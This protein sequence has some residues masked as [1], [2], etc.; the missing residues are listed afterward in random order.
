MPQSGQ[1]LARLWNRGSRMSGGVLYFYRTYTAT[2]SGS[3]RRRERCAGCSR[4][5]EYVVTRQV[6][7]GGHSAFLLNNAGAAA[8]AKMRARENLDRVLNETIEPVHCPTCGI[9]QT[10]MVRVLRERHGKRCEPNKYAS[11]Q[12]AVPVA[13]AWRAACA[14]NT[15]ESYTKFKEVWPA[16]SWH[17]EQQIKEIKYPLHVRKLVSSFGWIMWGALFALIVGISFGRM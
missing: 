3:R 13:S 12:I 16:H 5:F 6:E 10:D 7:G 15:V 11:E 2:A 17:A 4:V 1:E 9:F 8:N 14:A